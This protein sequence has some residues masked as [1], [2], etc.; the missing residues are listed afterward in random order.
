[1]L[2]YIKS[3]RKLI[4]GKW[5]KVRNRFAITYYTRKKPTDIYTKILYKYRY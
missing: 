4:G 2:I 3:Y 5:Y 1:M